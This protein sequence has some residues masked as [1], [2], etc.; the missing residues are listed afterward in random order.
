MAEIRNGSPAAKIAIYI[1]MI[2]FTVMAVYP[3]LWLAV[4]SFKTT[5]EYITTSK[6]ALPKLWFTGNYPYTWKM[7]KFGILMINSVIY[8]AVT[9]LAVVFLGFMAAFAFAKIRS[10]ATPF[11]HGM[12]I[13]GILLT[14]QSIMVPLF[15]MV[16]AVGLYNTRLGVLIPYIGLGLPMGVYLGTEF[17]KGIPDALIESAKIDGAKYLRIFWSIIFPM[18]APAAVT[19]GILTFTGTWNEFMLI[20]I[21]TSDDAIKSIPVGIGR[22]S[23]ALAS[24]YGKQFAALV[25]GM[26]PMLL[27]YV[28]FRRQITKGVAAGAVKG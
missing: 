27:F 21:L 2:L 25:I 11:L 4:M 3:L 5:Q 22:F 7:G 18:T 19:L 15:L 13:I 20:N 23:G 14:L 1:V 26:I 28:I 17:I 6:L 10:R 16:N 24:D 8:T 9:V 12:F